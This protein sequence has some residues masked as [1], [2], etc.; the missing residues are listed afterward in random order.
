MPFD[1]DH[2]FIICVDGVFTA[3]FEQIETVLFKIAYQ[4]TSLD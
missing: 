4:I 1:R 2:F 3:F